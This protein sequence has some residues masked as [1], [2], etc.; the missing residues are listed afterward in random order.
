M[1]KVFI[2]LACCVL[3][4]G[5]LL[6][7]SQAEAANYKIALM[8]KDSTTPFWRY[9]VTGAQEVAAKLGCEVIEYAPLQTQNLEEQV[10]QMEDAIQKGVSAICIAPIDSEG[11]IPAIE[12][13]NAAGIPVIT[14]NS[15]SAGGDIKTFVGVDNYEAAKTLAQYMM[16]KLG[17]KGNVVIIEGNPARQT[18]Q[19]RVRGFTEIIKKYPDVNLLVSQ[20]GMFQ[21][22]EAMNIMENIL[23]SNSNINAVLALNDEMALGSI[24]ALQDAG[25][26]GVWVTGF[27]GAKEGLEAIVAGTLFASMNQAPFD[28]G[29][30]AVQAAVDVLNGKTI[31]SWIK[32]GGEVCDAANAAEMLKRFK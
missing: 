16:D 19:D 30:M 32:V 23:Q 4:I 15:K 8:V 24:Q 14:T 6:S 11:I 9:V 5:L 26:K 3:V 10:R 7:G 13:A 18:S 20:P 29:G 31:D 22:A 21:R 12:K 28:Q 27:D 25:V 1:R 17:G 2:V